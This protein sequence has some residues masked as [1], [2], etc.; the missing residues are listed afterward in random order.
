IF[1]NWD[2]DDY[3]KFT[4]TSDSVLDLKLTGLTADAYVQLLDSTG[5]WII[6][7]YKDGIVDENLRRSLRVGTYYV[8]IQP[9]VQPDFSGRQNTNYSLNLVAT[10]IPADQA[11][12]NLATSRGI[13]VGS[14]A[15]S[16][17]DF[18][19]DFDRDDYYKFTL[20]NEAIINLE[21][22]ALTEDANL[23]LLNSTGQ[24]IRASFNRN[25]ENEGIQNILPAGNYYVRVYNGY[26]GDTTYKLT[27]FTTPVPLISVT[28]ADSTAT[29]TK[30]GQ[31]VDAGQ[32][33]L[34]RTGILTQ[35]LTVNYF[36][37]GTAT[38]ETDYTMTRVKTATFLPGS[39]TTI[40]NI[41]PV[42]DL[43]LEGD[44][45]VSLNLVTG[46]NYKAVGDSS[47][48]TIVDDEAL[49]DL[50]GNTLATARIIT[51][52]TV[53]STFNDFVGNG[54]EKDYYKFILTE[55]GNLSLHLTGLT[56]DADVR[57]LDGSGQFVWSSFNNGTANENIERA[58]KAGTYYVGVYPG[59][60]RNTNY[61]LSLKVPNAKELA[62]SIWNVTAFSAT[63]VAKTLKNNGFDLVAIADALDDGLTGV[64]DYIQ[65]AVGL[66]NS[67][68][69]LNARNLA[70]LL[71]DEGATERDI[72]KALKYLGFDL[73][74]IADALDDGVTKRDGTKLNYTGVAVGLWN[75]G[76]SMTGGKLADLLWDEGASLTQIGQALNYGIGRDLLHIASD[77]KYGITN[78]DG[79]NLTFTQVAIALWNSGGSVSTRLL[80]DLLWDVGASAAEIGKA[81]NYGIGRNLLQIASDLR[82]GVTTASGGS[83]NYTDIALGLWNS[84]H[85]INPRLLAD[86]LWDTGATQ[87]EIGKALNYGIGR[88]LLQ[89]AS[90]MKYG[91][92]TASGG[93]LNYTDVAVGLWNSGH[94]F[95]TRKLADLLWDTG[96]TQAEIGKALNYGIGRNLLQIASDLR[97]GVTTASGGS[98]NYTDIALGLWNSGHSINSR[99][100][101]DVLWDTGASLS[102][103]A[104]ALYY[105]EFK[106]SLPAI[107]DAL[108]D[109]VTNSNNT[110]LSYTQVAIALDSIVLQGTTLASLLWNEGAKVEQ[111]SQSLKYLGFNLSQIAKALD[112]GIT[113][114]NYTTVAVGLWNSGHRIDSSQL[115]RL[116]WDEGANLS[117]IA[118]ALNRGIVRNLSQIAN[119]MK[120][121]IGINYGQMTIAL[122]NSGLPV[123]QRDVAKILRDFG[124]SA[125][126]VGKSLRNEL[127][128]SLEQIAD[129][130]DDGADYS[131]NDVARGIWNSG[132]GPNADKLARLLRAEGANWDQAVAALDAATELSWGEAALAVSKTYVE[133]WFNQ[134]IQEVKQIGNKIETFYE[135]NKSTLLV[136]APGLVIAVEATKV[137]GK[138]IESGNIEPIVDGLKRIPVVGTAVSILDGVY[139]AATGNEKGVLEE[140]IN[141]ALAFYG[142]SNAVTPTM[143]EFVVDIFWELK[144]L[145]Y[146]G[147]ISATL[148]N[149][150][151]PKTVSDRF[152]AVA[153][154]VAVDPDWQKAMNSAL[155]KVGFANADKFVTMAWDIVDKNYKEALSTGL[156]LV[157]FSNL[158]IDQAK[159]DA[160]LNLAVAIRDGNPTQAADI[161]IALSG[162]NQQ[163]I[164]SSWVK[165]LKDGNTANDRQAI[166][167]GLTNLGFQNGT[168]WGDVIWGVKDGKYLDALSTILTLGNFADGRDWIKI[169]DNIQ[170]QNYLE[171]LSTA[172]KVAEFPDGQSLADAV[173]A[174][175]NG[176]YVEAFFESINLIEGGRDLA[177]AFKYLMDFNLGEFVTSITKPEVL[178]LL[179]KY[180]VS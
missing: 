50:A 31:S 57:L 23:Q 122:W 160:F 117:E 131:W 142:G 54:D 101:A 158:G 45:T 113:T 51:V 123:N 132:H 120:N 33:V 71:W 47:I 128:A 107:A 8:Q 95:D 46:S 100:L 176:K 17:N 169:I 111:V 89:I 88:N 75:S 170:K 172:F 13:T 59:F 171:A 173:L 52:G 180:F 96:A 77:M 15:S 83:L 109:G 49:P 36:V 19:G 9:D 80:A 136:V 60:P 25:L 115:A 103:L 7:S 177:D 125:Q 105:Y 147:A 159:A 93:S 64:F 137:I 141:S 69:S 175:K 130:L 85:S 174:V 14:T 32:F 157:G 38:Q 129:A 121:G 104:Q 81:L 118:Q 126:D 119:D 133:D 11:G 162:N 164:Q 5:K 148:E 74:T 165:D 138:S 70:D 82:Y 94:S 179:I 145:D 28:T 150:G 20:T 53:P 34:T 29:E 140:A 161:L 27:L 178:S 56:A 18:V 66:W 99:V 39:S 43:I 90:D 151:M 4:L 110:Y 76:H 163:V 87:A 48:I 155:T 78:S 41:T 68:Y 153:W 134:T 144:D 168:Q 62:K 72:G 63:D 152:T 40:V 67:G 1:G 30:T 167:Q 84:G 42:D 146:Q 12:N 58:L 16:F 37:S 92:T 55:G 166:Q 135:D 116:L 98:L 24:F 106:L 124:A 21:L 61:T 108:A 149:L 73:P 114:I 156:Q 2:R 143:V 6:G 139:K 79:T 44:E 154:S 35:S 91:I 10:T 97:Y 22:T 127:G 112:D 65:I 26:P 86:L 3:Y 102:Q